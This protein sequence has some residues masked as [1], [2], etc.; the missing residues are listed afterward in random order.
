[1]RNFVE[2]FIHQAFLWHALVEIDVLRGEILLGGM[3]FRFNV[4]PYQLL[5]P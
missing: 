5:Y 1:M 4:S 2:G 3:S